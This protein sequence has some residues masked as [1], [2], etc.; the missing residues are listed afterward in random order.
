MGRG[1]DA[2][3]PVIDFL[4]RSANHGG[5]AVKRIDTHAASV[6]LTGDRVLK[7]KRAV[8]FP[9][10]DYSTLAKRK[11]ACE[12]E[13]EVNRL[14]APDIYRGV[15]PITRDADGRLAIDGKGE[16]VEWAVEMAR[17]D[18]AQT[19]DHLAEDGRIDTALADALGRAVAKAH[20]AVPVATDAGFAGTLA[21]IIDQN[22]GEL[23]AASDLFA[24]DD[25]A[26]LTAASRDALERL[27]PLLDRARAGGLRAP[28]SWRSASRQ[29]RLDRWRAGAVRCHRVQSEACHH[30]RASTISPSC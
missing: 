22:D 5:T 30:R 17:F 6:F 8:R 7:I 3:Q 13:I 28:M 14:Y 19:L 25:V 9:F 21:E 11:E 10:L 15:V 29:Y 23:R 20:V 2:Q 27:R 18:E 16:P 24:A 4:S 1:S 26:A 12:A